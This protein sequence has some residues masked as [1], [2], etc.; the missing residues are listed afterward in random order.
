MISKKSFPMYCD[1]H[2]LFDALT[3]DQAGQLIK[4]VFAHENGGTPALE[5]MLHGIYMLIANQLDRDRDKYTQTC[6]RNR[7]NGSKGGRPVKA[8]QTQ[9]D[10]PVAPGYPH[11]PQK[12]DTDTDTGTGT[13]TDTDTDTDMCVERPC[14]GAHTGAN[15]P[16]THKRPAVR[17]LFREPDLEE[18]SAYCL[19]QKLSVDAQRFI[20][21]Y[22]SKGWM[23]G[24][25]PMKDWQAALRNWNK[26]ERAAPDKTGYVPD[27]QYRFG[28]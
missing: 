3:D 2:D 8:A 5:G 20:D 10:V 18:V 24:S 21:Y 11:K 6:A 12:P 15:A 16:H 1:Y 17:S 28:R 26:G 7:K 19:A 13:G 14:A 9:A 4:A 27:D 25:S 23:V 22:A